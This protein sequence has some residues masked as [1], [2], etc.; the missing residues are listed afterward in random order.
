MAIT[1]SDILQTFNSGTS[2]SSSDQFLIETALGAAMKVSAEWVRAYLSAGV[3]PNTESIDA[4][5]LQ[6]NALKAAVS[7]KQEKLVSGVNIKTVNGMSLLGSGNVSIETNTDDIDALK[8]AVSGK[9]D[10]L[11]SDVNIKTVNGMSLLGSGDVSIE[12]LRHVFLEEDEMNALTAETAEEGVIYFGMEPL[13]VPPAPPAP[14]VSFADNTVT[15]SAAYA[16]NAVSF[17]AAYADN[18]VKTQ[19]T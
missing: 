16:D 5:I 6:L 12:S 19:T 4:L 11:V 17:A 10:K 18:S 3:K 1:Q 14:S 2:V 9:Q 15:A 7:G 13:D 8:T